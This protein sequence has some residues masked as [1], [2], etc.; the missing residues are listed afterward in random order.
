MRG[1][2]VISVSTLSRWRIIPADAGSTDLKMVRLPIYR[3]HPRGCGEHKPSRVD[4][5]PREGSSPR[6]RGAHSE[7]L[8]PVRARR[9]IRADAGSTSRPMPSSQTKGDHPR[10]CGEH[11]LTLML[12]SPA[13]GSSPRMRGAP[14]YII[15]GAI[16]DRIIPADA[17]STAAHVPAHHTWQDHPRGC[18]EHA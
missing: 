12:A 14:F 17:G 10:G 8:V 5:G 1:A 16:M 3:D 13:G 15:K 2:R 6:M 4:Q 7:T 11:F 18:G 9:I